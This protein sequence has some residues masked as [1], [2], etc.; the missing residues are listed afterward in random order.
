MIT[1]GGSGTNDG[2][3]GMIEA[4]GARFYAE[5]G[6]LL[7]MC[8]GALAKVSRID[9]SGL[10]KRLFETKF[11]FACDVTNPLVG[12]KGATYIYGAQKGADAAM[13]ERLE[14]GMKNYAARLADAC[15]KDISDH[16]GCGAGGGL[17]SP[18][19][20]ICGAEIRSGI[21]SVLATLDFDKK[22]E[23][24]K[25]IIT[26]EGKIDLQSAFGKAI[27]G[28][29]DAAKKQNIPVIALVGTK[30][31]GADQLVN[32]G[33]LRVEATK[34]IAP[35]VEYSM[36]HADVLLEKLAASVLEELKI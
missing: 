30:G 24:A 26:G 19:V 34:D 5:N 15:G 36:N 25:L 17:A 10:D 18:L 32:F 8:G 13:L 16:P 14:A 29:T 28:V 27:S 4:L 33:I 3:S 22:I 11:T 9:I 23:G 6:E 21:S 35:S 2:G 1:V 7:S 31:E 12:E 20:A